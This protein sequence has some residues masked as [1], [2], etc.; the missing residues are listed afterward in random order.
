MDGGGAHTYSSTALCKRA[1]LLAAKSVGSLALA[2][3]AGGASTRGAARSLLIPSLPTPAT[4]PV[5]VR[6]NLEDVAV[7][8]ASAAAPPRR[9]DARLSRRAGTNP[10]TGAPSPPGSSRA[11]AVGA[12]DCRERLGRDG[13]RRLAPSVC[14]AAGGAP[15]VPVPGWACLMR[16]SSWAA[17][18]A[19]NSGKAPQ[20]C[21]G[22]TLGGVYS[23][24]KK[25]QRGTYSL[26]FASLRL[27]AGSGSEILVLR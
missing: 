5:T 8:A 15:P 7:R 17:A 22:T 12:A 14:A 10:G 11:A 24:S 19:H 27:C 20:T 21:V 3:A 13:L 9:R 4:R 23:S 2:A 16:S 1:K 26:A 6:L 18:H 25:R